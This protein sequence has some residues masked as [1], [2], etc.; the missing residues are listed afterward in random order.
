[1]GFREIVGQD[2]AKRTLVNSLR[3][4]RL[5]SAY[6]FYG[7]KGIGKATAAFALAKAV[8]CKQEGDDSCDSCP[9]CRRIENLNYPDVRVIL[10]TP[11]GVG[12]ED[13]SWTPK[14]GRPHFGH[15]GSISIDTIRSLRREIALKPY[16]AE[17]RM[18]ILLDADCMTVE[19]SNAFLKALEEPPLDTTFV[20]TTTRASY[21]LPTILSRCQRIP[22]RR[23]SR[24]EIEESLVRI[25]GV[26]SRRARSVSL[27]SDGSLGRALELAEEGGE[28]ERQ[29][30]VELISLPPGDRWEALEEK[31]INPAG[32]EEMVGLLL[33]TYRDLLVFKEM[34]EEGV[35]NRDLLSQL[36]VKANAISSEQIRS[37]IDSL[38]D[39]S[40]ALARNVNPKLVWNG[41][42]VQLS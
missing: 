11:P 10:P 32:V 14:E 17:R 18:I 15:K 3:S 8:N 42:I 22:F 29:R 21:L 4:G 34:G 30:V 13:L 16:E 40:R 1:M 36:R 5:A 35:V 12:L 33:L 24:E 37:S 2:L 9:S 39:A 6:L 41:L 26:D 27:I 28:T 23:L 31:Q 38:M 20:L 19:A 7:P 25:A